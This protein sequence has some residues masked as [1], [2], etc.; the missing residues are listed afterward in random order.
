MERAMILTRHHL[1]C[2]AAI[3]LATFAVA[4][5]AGAQTFPNRPL[6]LI[7]PFAAGSTADNVARVL[8]AKLTEQLGQQVIVDTRPGGT[9]VIGIEI[10]KNAPPNG[11]TL[12]M[13]GITALALLPA[14]KPKLPYDA[15]RDFIALT[16]ATSTSTV[17]VVHPS[18]GVST[19]A[20]LVK[21]ARARP[22]QLNYGSAGHGSAQHIGAEL[23]N[24]MAGVKTVHVPYKSANLVL[25]DLI[26]GQVQFMIVSAPAV[27]SQA[28]A[29]RVKLIATTG[30]VRD[31]LLPELPIV[32]DVLP[33]Y[34]ITS[35]TGIA[36]PAKT[37]VAIVNKLHGDIVRALRTA[38]VREQYAKQGATAHPES[39]AEFT[40]FIKAERER[41]ARIGRQVGITLD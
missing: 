2:R 10:A 19:V 31:P 30:A 23:F 13:A 27:M 41:I 29:G 32:A 33:G 38:D 18:L 24:L 9:G 6:R 26:A 20:E 11:Y 4:G 36:V 22:G 14:L 25:P 39:A 15:D 17:V 35:W 28:K 1:L 3:M 7:V 16:R 34:E 40:A 5:N 37:P 8:S 21:L 12:L